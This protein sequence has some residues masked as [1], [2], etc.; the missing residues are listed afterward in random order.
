MNSIRFNRETR[1]AFDLVFASMFGH[2]AAKR[3]QR[4][5]ENELDEIEPALIHGSF[6][7]KRPEMS[8]SL[9]VI[10]IF[11]SNVLTLG[12]SFVLTMALIRLNFISVVPQ[13][14][15]KTYVAAQDDLRPR[16][17]P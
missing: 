12:V 14:V 11:A 15:A 1:K 17:A 10:A 13:M 4:Q 2:T 8:Q 9:I 7:A 5:I 6:D 3:A 16:R